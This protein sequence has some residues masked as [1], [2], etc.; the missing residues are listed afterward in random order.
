MTVV[1][2]HPDPASMEEHMRVAMPSSGGLPTC[3][4]FEP[5]MC[6]ANRARPF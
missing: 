2:V 3:S 5:W 6:T 4:P 1:Q